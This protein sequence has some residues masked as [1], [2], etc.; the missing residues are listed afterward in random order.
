MFLPKLSSAVIVFSLAI[1]SLTL[2]AAGKESARPQFKNV[3]FAD[4]FSAR[5]LSPHWKGYKSDSK[6]ENGV[7]VG[8]KPK[9]AD[10]NAVDSVMTRPYSDVEVSLDFQ[11]AGSPLFVVAF[12]EHRFKGSH[13]GHICRVVLTPRRVTLR[14]GKTGVFQNEIFNRRRAGALD[15]KTKALLKTKEVITPVD[16]EQGKWYHL[17]V[18]IQADKMMLFIDGNKISELK[19][20]GI[21]HP[22]KN[23]LSLVTSKQ[24]MHFDNFKIVVP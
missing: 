5:Q 6:I 3:L 17:L 11:F 19:S 1:P 13:A 7:L 16:F 18:R 9:T 22:T 14:D 21:A 10:H 8:L 24:A 20:E 2:A 12:N 15:Q 23:K 4:D